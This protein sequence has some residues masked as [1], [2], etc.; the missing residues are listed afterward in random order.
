MR[1]NN[2]HRQHPK[3]T[4][5]ELENKHNIIMRK[6]LILSNKMKVLL[7]ISTSQT[8]KYSNVHIIY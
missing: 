1:W 6:K 3:A 2:E 8:L 5:T 7:L 4:F